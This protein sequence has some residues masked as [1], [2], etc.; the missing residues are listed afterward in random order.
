M[1]KLLVSNFLLHFSQVISLGFREFMAGF[2]LLYLF[3]YFINPGSCGFQDHLGEGHE[4]WHLSVKHFHIKWPLFHH[5]SYGLNS[6]IVLI[7]SS[8]YL[9][10]FFA[11]LLLRWTH[12]QDVEKF[13]WGLVN[14]VSLPLF[15]LNQ[16]QQRSR[17]RLWESTKY[18]KN[19]KISTVFGCLSIFVIIKKVSSTQDWELPSN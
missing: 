10:F 18:Q 12:F 14:P 6:D 2:H 11:Y 13:P 5:L 8:V 1:S 9:F 4:V 15:R 17:L 3:H 16:S 19:K 7:I